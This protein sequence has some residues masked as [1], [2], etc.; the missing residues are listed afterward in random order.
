MLKSVQAQWERD[1]RSGL[2]PVFAWDKAGE[3]QASAPVWLE[4]ATLL[5]CVRATEYKGA[6]GRREWAQLGLARCARPP[7]RTQPNPLF[8]ATS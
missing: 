1:S 6:R 2:R 5:R 8:A 4:Y 7:N 3:D